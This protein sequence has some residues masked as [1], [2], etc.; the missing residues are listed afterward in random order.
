MAK[1]ITHRA[2]KGFNLKF[3]PDA[4]WSASFYKGLNKLQY[5]D[6]VNILNINRDDATGFRLDTLTT[7]KQYKTPT[8]K[9]SEVLTTRTEYVNKYPSTLQTTSYNFTG[10]DTTPEVCVGVVKAS[11]LHQKNPAQHISDLIMLSNVK[12]LKPL[13]INLGSNLSK[14]VDCI[15]VD[16]AADEGPSHET[17]Q[18]WWTYWHVT[19]HKVATLVTTRCSGSSYLNRVELQNG[20]L[21][22]GHANTFIPS[23][24]AGSCIDNDNGGIDE[25]KLK[26]NLELAITA[27]ISRTNGCPCG[28]GTI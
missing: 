12:E 23:T 19:Q 24:L 20:C 8:V 28:G 11:P 27:Y 2:R 13:F 1:V 5:R 7:C 17:I 15:R 4:H 26:E 6:G 25:S 3:N 14:E 16:G 18:Y 9:G 10:T 21:S 22:L